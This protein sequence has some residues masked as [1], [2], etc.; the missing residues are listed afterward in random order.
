MAFCFQ[1]N[2]AKS[3]FFRYQSALL[4]AA[5]SLVFI[6]AVVSSHVLLHDRVVIQSFVFIELAVSSQL[7]VQLVFHNFVLSPAVKNRFVD[8]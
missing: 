4:V 6:L 3:S 5:H 8:H 7:L 2:V 1:L